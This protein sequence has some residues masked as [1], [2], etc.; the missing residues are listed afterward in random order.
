M[1]NNPLVTISIPTFNS[2]VFIRLCLD[3]IK[4][5]TYKNI[6]I[7]VIDGNSKDH[8][9]EIAR[10]YGVTVVVY[11]DALLGARNEGLKLAQGDLILLLDS[12]QILE[13]TAIERAVKKI[14]ADD[15]DMLIFEED[16]YKNDKFIEH[17]FHYDRKLV[18]AVKDFN[19]MTSVMLP[20]FYKSDLLRRAFEK[21]PEDIQRNVGGQDHAI[22]YLEAWNISQRVDILSGA[23]KHIEPNTFK[24]MWKKFYR[25]GYTSVG[26]R[27]NKYSDLLGK[28]ERFRK[29]LFKHGMIKASNASIL[30]LLIKGVPYKI[31]YFI[32][33][34]KLNNKFI[35]VERYSEIAPFYYSGDVPPSLVKLLARPFQTFLDCG[36]GDGSLLFALRKSGA[37]EG[38]DVQAVDLSQKRVALVRQMDPAARVTVDSV[39]SLSTIASASIDVLTSTMVI[40]HV[41]DHAMLRAIA[42]VL[43]PGAAAYV[44]TVFKKPFAWYF[45]R[46]NKGEWAIDPTHLREYRQEKELFD[47]LPSNLRVVEERKTQQWFP[48]IDFIIKNLRIRNR[49]ILASGP[50]KNIRKLKVPILGYYVWEIVFQKAQA[51]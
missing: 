36:C 8:T 35:D 37:L 21:I 45:Y 2:E 31:G 32:G 25:W 17:L 12:D 16:V 10:Q 28:K 13:P 34:L 5:Q 15:L 18:H 41:D 39:E 4:A 48:V 50:L 6:E 22:I 42:R 24:A 11:N 43:K 7:N 30:L 23:V 44:T 29:G 9:I 33:K 49:H 46:N 40:E 51:Q 38:K 20:R 19:P 14:L 27:A 26:A 3:S 47:K 1:N